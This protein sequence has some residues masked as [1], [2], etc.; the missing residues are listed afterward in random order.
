MDDVLV[1]RILSIAALALSVA[2][3]GGP[4]PHAATAS[5]RIVVPAVGQGAGILVVRDGAAIAFD[6]G[7]DSSFVLS[8][9]LRTEGIARAEL[10]IVSHW[11]LDHVGGL[12]ALIQ[13]G[14]VEQIVHGGEPVEEWMRSKKRA[15]C[16]KVPKGCVLVEQG[17]A[18]TVLGDFATEFVRTDPDGATNNDRSLVSRL[19]DGGGSGLLLAPGD[20]DTSGEAAIL[21]RN[22]PIRAEFLLAAHH[23]SRGSSSLPFLGA[24]RA[25]TVFVQAGRGNAYGHPHVE[26]L[27]RLREVVADLRVV[28]DVGTESVLP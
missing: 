20:I 5:A 8:R 28:A 26:A 23:G 7:P 3:C 19:V 27:E 22:V 17:R 16:A 21:S 24:V 14:Q 4:S 15:W 9:A 2:S 12:D 6:A 13:A 11:D 1:R 10:L 18:R 25:R